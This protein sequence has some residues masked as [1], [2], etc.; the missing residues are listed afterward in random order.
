MFPQLTYNV[1]I[2]CRLSRD[3]GNDSISMSIQNQKDSLIEY[4]NSKNWN[5]VDI[6]VD[7]G[8]TGTNFNRPSFQRLITDI[9]KKKINCVITK[10]LSR[11]GRNYLQTGYYTEE[12]FPNNDVRYIALN[13]N[14]DTVKGDNDFAPFK[15]IINEWYAKDISKKVR[16]S[17][18]QKMRQPKV[19]G[20]SVPLYG[21]NHN[22]N[23]ERVIN[24]ETAPI[25]RLMADMYIAG[26]STVVIAKFLKDKGI[27][28]P[29]Y[30]N[31]LTYGANPNRHKD[32]QTLEEKCD[33]SPTV[34]ARIIKSIEYTGTLINHK[35]TN[36]SFKNKK[37]L[38]VPDEERYV[39][40]QVFEPIL[41]L[42]EH[43]LI[44]KI[45]QQQERA[46]IPL[47]E[48]MFLGLVYCSSC[49]SIEK[50]Q[51]KTEK[52]K[53]T[54]YVYCCRNKNCKGHHHIKISILKETVLQELLQI[55]KE[56]QSKEDEFIE[57]ASK[58]IED[59][60]NES[61][62]ELNRN[63]YKELKEQSDILDN[64]IAKLFEANLN[65]EIPTST[66]TKMMK[67][68]TDQKTDIERKIESLFTA[69]KPTEKVDYVTQAKNILSA[70]SQID[71]NTIITRELIVK[72]IDSI[73]VEKINKQYLLKIKYKGS[74]ILKEFIKCNHQH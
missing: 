16:F 25:V 60:Q 2:Y 34:I 18:T 53:P 11:L 62:E 47:E 23:N 48:N 17:L 20:C 7:D 32:M 31:Y 67:T 35:T 66:Y 27:Y 52:N 21:Y 3:D 64:K 4:V 5:L 69:S 63:L 58:Y 55:K 49:G 50:Y 12:F 19:L 8:F 65:D 41:T 6:Y 13:D 70:I 36:R 33:W 1:G 45:M 22:K 42:H 71:D 10:D 74:K 56:L 38:Q 57:F 30:Y 68:Y 40:D 72:L 29:A 51:R 24:P 9:E 61:Q 37:K 44:N 26:N 59:N 14:F 28:T 15:N 73:T 39:F 46:S 43:N 54:R